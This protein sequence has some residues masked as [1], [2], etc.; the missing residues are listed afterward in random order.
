MIYMDVMKIKGK[1]HGAPWDKRAINRT[2]RFNIIFFVMFISGLA[3]LF[4]C[5]GIY[6]VLGLLVFLIS[7]A[8]IVQ[9][10]NYKFVLPKGYIIQCDRIV[11]D[12]EWINKIIPFSEI[13]EIRYIKDSIG[14][15]DSRFQ[16]RFRSPGRYEHELGPF[17]YSP[18]VYT[19]DFG[20]VHSYCNRWSEFVM[21]ITEHYK[22][23]L[24]APDN[25][26]EFIKELQ[27]HNH[28]KGYGWSFKRQGV[29]RSKPSKQD[30]VRIDWD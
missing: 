13:R 1:Y 7:I 4:F 23:Y 19:T 8:Y 30:D 18:R 24:L 11:I 14:V 27:Q 5:G 28:S 17:G 3:L 25:P 20:T 21:I 9:I 16:P 22:P 29:N 10:V 6:E 12:K 2:R 15:N 26:H